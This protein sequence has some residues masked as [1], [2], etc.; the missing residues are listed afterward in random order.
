M[1]GLWVPRHQKLFGY[2]VRD[3]KT[4]QEIILFLP[5]NSLEEAKAI[6]EIRKDSHG[7]NANL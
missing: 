7:N 6:E 2:K 3:E 4:G 1:A 5:P